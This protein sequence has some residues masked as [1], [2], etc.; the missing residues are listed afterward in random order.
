[1]CQPPA[2]GVTKPLSSTTQRKYLDGSCFTFCFL[3]SFANWVILNIFF[4]PPKV[5]IENDGTW[6]EAK[7]SL[8]D[9]STLTWENFNQEQ[10]VVPFGR[11]L[12]VAKVRPGVVIYY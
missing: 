4:P 12:R 1:M 10:F 11:R 6:P 3:N 8:V 7:N 2:G 5:L 9:F